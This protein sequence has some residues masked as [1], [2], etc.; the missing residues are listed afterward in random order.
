MPSH[1]HT[2]PPNDSAV[3][4]DLPVAVD[5]HGPATFVTL[6]G[7]RSW[8]RLWLVC[9]PL[10]LP[11]PAAEGSLLFLH[12]ADNFLLL[13]SKLREV[14]GGMVP[15]II[16][17]GIHFTFAGQADNGQWVGHVGTSG[18]LIT[19]AA[20]I[21]IARSLASERPELGNLPEALDLQLVGALVNVIHS[22][23][24]PSH[25]CVHPRGAQDTFT[26]LQRQKEVKLRAIS[27]L[28]NNMNMIDAEVLWTSVPARRDHRL[29][30]H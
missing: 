12:G 17:V 19:I 30:Q 1:H 29:E 14:R 10:P 18:G 25:L 16:E 22:T 5:V 28:I 20:I 7:Q 23:H 8:R 6:R 13:T 27:L 2:Q 15:A 4:R 21:A 3:H 9:L 11:T 26:E 24:G